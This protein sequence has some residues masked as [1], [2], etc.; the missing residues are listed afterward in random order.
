MEEN[1]GPGVLY[2]K[3]VVIT[4]SVYLGYNMTD[5]PQSRNNRLEKAKPHLLRIAGGSIIMLV[6]GCMV[7]LLIGLCAAYEWIFDQSHWA[8]YWKAF[9]LSPWFLGAAYA[10]GGIVE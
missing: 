8:W 9:S 2:A 3:H 4:S 7:F 1:A 5:E 10:F 6:M